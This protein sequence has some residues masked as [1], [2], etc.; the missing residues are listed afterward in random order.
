[1]SGRAQRLDRLL[2][3]RR[4][5]E[6]LDRRTLT[7]ALA[8]VAEVEMALDDQKVQVVEARQTAREGLDAGDRGKWLMADAQTEVAGWNRERLGVLLEARAS[9]V[10][11][12]MAKFMESRCEHEQV[13]K[14]IENAQEIEKIEE[15][16]KAQA[17]SDDW[18][19]SRRLRLNR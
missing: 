10:P 12:A 5:S 19:L 13:K 16:R 1:M 7:L 3:I 2:V 11:P 15:G 18:F 14:L 9:E 8:S 4:L 6:E 17:A